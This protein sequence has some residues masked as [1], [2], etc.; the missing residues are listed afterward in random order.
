MIARVVFIF[1]LAMAAYP[2][3]EAAASPRV[4]DVKATPIYRRSFY[5]SSS[6]SRTFT[7]TNLQTWPSLGCDVADTFMVVQRPNGTA[8]ANDNCNSSTLASCV[9]APG[10]VGY[11]TV[12]I[13]ASPASQQPSPGVSLLAGAPLPEPGKC[14]FADLRMNSTLV[15][16]GLLFGG[17][18]VNEPVSGNLRAQTVHIPGGADDTVLYA[19]GPSW[20]HLLYNNDSGIGRA[21]AGT[22]SLP[23]GSRFVVG[24]FSMGSAGR[25]RLVLNDCPGMPDSSGQDA[26]QD[27][28]IDADG[29]NLSDVLEAELGTDPDHHDT[30]RDGIFDFYEVIGRV[31]GSDELELPRL[32][33]NPRRRDVF[34]E[35][36]RER[37]AEGV[38]AHQVTLAEADLK[39]EDPYLDLPQMPPAPDGTRAIFLH[40]DT[41][42]Q[43]DGRPSLCGDWG[44]SEIVSMTWTD[45]LE[46]GNLE[47]HFSPARRGVFHYG[48]VT[49]GGSGQG[50]TGVTTFY[51]SYTSGIAHELGHNLGLYHEGGANMPALNSKPNY[52]S[53]MSYNYLGSLPNVTM[54]RG[55]FSEGLLPSLDGPIDEATWGSGSAVAYLEADP[56]GYTIDAG[57]AI[58]LNRDNRIG[59]PGGETVQCDVAP[60][61]KGTTGDDPWPHMAEASLL[62][63]SPAQTGC[64][65]CLPSGGAAIAVQ[66][67]GAS[68][69]LA[70]FVPYRHAS[71]FTYPDVS[72][73]FGSLAWSPMRPLPALVGLPTGEVAAEALD[74]PGRA[75]VVFPHYSGRLHYLVVD[76][77]SPTG[78]VWQEIPGWPAGTTARQANI[79]RVGDRLFAI[80]RDSSSDDTSNNVYSATF[81]HVT[82]TWS[83]IRAEPIASRFTPDVT[84]ASDGNAYLAYIDRV[85]NNNVEGG[86]IRIGY[87]SASDNSQP[88]TVYPAASNAGWELPEPPPPEYRQR[89]GLEFVP[90]RS[91]V[92]GAFPD[93]SGQLVV[94]W[95][96]NDWEPEHSGNKDEWFLYRAT[97]SGF[98]APGGLL[99]QGWHRRFDKTAERPLPNHSVAT[100]MRGADML[101]IYSSTSWDDGGALQGARYLPYASG[102]VPGY[103]GLLDHDD[104]AVMAQTLCSSVWHL[105]DGAAADCRCES[106]RAC[107][108]FAGGVL[109]EEIT[110]CE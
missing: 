4:H 15:E 25:T 62:E 56:F 41:G 28:G 63:A 49:T 11:W 38:I 23:P 91:S 59:G 30:D 72:D 27:A 68:T 1:A 45:M 75:L 34:L 47:D 65:P 78:A 22:V 87:R 44:G 58:D 73:T 57:G 33:A 37:N 55:R 89:L 20:S 95:V 103:E 52:P 51:T 13:F 81:D 93:Q 54:G 64:Q 61:D 90:L 70:A 94:S 53:L 88:W 32:G 66:P 85:L 100:A 86:Q 48:Y 39:L 50:G 31:V 16:S 105:V 5:V 76:V 69:W 110:T 3:M 35:L 6:S 40:I 99:L 84:V 24:S 10:A 98:I 14:G 18:V 2:P 82:E 26:C 77:A 79:A 97:L 36:D 9:T 109:A 29:D 19:F 17:Q 21:A 67:V 71:G 60:I 42:A 83:A 43:C 46:G 7:T 12:T 104:A 74:E 96:R 102:V 107:A 101:A 8:Y 106:G 92:T 80:W 108:S